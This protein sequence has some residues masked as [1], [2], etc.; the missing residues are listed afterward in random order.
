MG[1]KSIKSVEGCIPLTTKGAT[2]LI[3]IKSAIEKLFKDDNIT[4]YQI[5][6]ATGVSQV[7]LNKFSKGES[8][9]DNMPLGNALKLYDFYLKLKE[10]NK[11]SNDRDILFGKILAVVNVLSERVFG[12]GKPSNY[13]TAFKKFSNAPKEAFTKMHSY[14][15][16]YSEK[17]NKEENELFDKLSEIMYELDDTEFNN[18]PLGDKYLLAYHKQQHELAK[19]RPGGEND[20]N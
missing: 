10:E 17:F 15:L 7:S 9:I 6:K 2:T 20:E 16:Q 11:L 5:S 14:I 18:E 1:T 8:N 12:G 4:N 3:D 13:Q 19:Y